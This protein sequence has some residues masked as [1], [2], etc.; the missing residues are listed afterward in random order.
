MTMKRKEKKKQY[1]TKRERKF[2]EN[3]AESDQQISLV[4]Q[5]F[6]LVPDNRTNVIVEA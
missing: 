1:E 3:W 4:Q 6:Q 2:Q 5:T